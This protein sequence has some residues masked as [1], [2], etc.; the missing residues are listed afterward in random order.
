[1]HDHTDYGFIT[2]LPRSG[3][4]WLANYL[5]YGNVMMLHDAWVTASP[6]EIKEKFNKENPYAAGT[7]DPANALMLDQIDK[8]FPDAKWVVITRPVEEVKEA[9]EKIHFPFV[10]FTSNLKKLMDSRKVLKV[11]FKTMFKRANEIGAYIYPEWECPKW[12]LAQLTSLNVQLHWGRV[13]DQFKV[14]EVV[15]ELESMTP[16]KMSYY[17]LIREIVNEDPNAMRFVTQAR[18]ASELFRRL[19][20]GKPL[21]IKKAMDTLE[22]MATEWLISPFVHQFSQSLVPAIV[23]ALEKYRT[24]PVGKHCPIDI[25]L[26]TTVTY[27][28]RGN[29]GVKEFMPKVRELAERIAKEKL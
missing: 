23:G 9:C 4:A 25:D 5:S 16:D 19:D 15:K 8:E 24:D 20:Q 13:S 10:D 2:G 11:P 21:D 1:M 6:Y 12:R 28:F 3:T 26:L 7:S 22:V 18:D 14:P 29:D 17:K 27:I